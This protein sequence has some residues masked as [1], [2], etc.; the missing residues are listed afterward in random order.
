MLLIKWEA[1]RITSLTV[2]RVARL[3]MD[4]DTKRGKREKSKYGFGNKGEEE[5]PWS[6]KCADL[7]M[8]RETFDGWKMDM[9][10]ITPLFVPIQMPHQ[11]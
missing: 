1:Q 11:W 2:A 7:D 8:H 4:G 9:D 5:L 6:E 3:M 10:A